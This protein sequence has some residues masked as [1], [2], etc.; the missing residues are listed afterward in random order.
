[1]ARLF[2]VLLLSLVLGFGLSACA[3]LLTA[4]TAAEL[5][6]GRGDD[7]RRDACEGR[8]EEY[9]QGVYDECIDAEGSQEDCRLRAGEAH[10]E[11]MEDCQGDGEPSECEEGCAERARGAYGECI[12]DGGSEEECREVYG[13][14]YDE[15]IEN[16]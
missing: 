1:M 2:P 13:E 15:C 4:D 9:A 11:C 5:D 16:C 6:N 12:D 14:V 7:D 8:C 10:D 3:P